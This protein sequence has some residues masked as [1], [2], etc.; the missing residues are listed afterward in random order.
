[1]SKSDIDYSCNFPTGN[2]T[3]NEMQKGWHNG[4]IIWSGGFF[5]IM[6]RAEKD[7]LGYNVM[8]IGSVEK[9]DLKR[10]RELPKE[11]MLEISLV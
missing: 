6:Y 2:Y 8:I 7:S 4:D 5:S 9:E 10:L 11:V 3:I 1:M